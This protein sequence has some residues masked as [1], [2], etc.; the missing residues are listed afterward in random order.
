MVVSA[1]STRCAPS[2]TQCLTRGAPVVNI[3]VVRV[4]VQIQTGPLVASG[5]AAVTPPISR[6]STLRYMSMA[7]FAAE[8][9]L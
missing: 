9:T 4:V 2:T 8:L 5:R 6:S 7:A 1:M 3:S